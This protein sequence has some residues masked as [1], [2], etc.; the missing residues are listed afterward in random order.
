MAAAAGVGLAV[1]MAAAGAKAAAAPCPGQ[2]E[3]RRGERYQ[4]PTEQL[5]GM[6]QHQQQ[7]GWRSYPSPPMAVVEAPV[8][9]LATVVAAA[10]VDSEVEPA[11]L[12]CAALPE[13]DRARA[14]RWS[15]AA[16]CKS[17][18]LHDDTCWQGFDETR[19]QQSALW[20]VDPCHCVALRRN[21]TQCTSRHCALA[22]KSHRAAACKS[23]REV[24][25]R[26]VRRQ[27][28]RR[29]AQSPRRR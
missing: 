20:S 4:L 21:L 22:R 12:P 19:W 17:H 25:V 15:G 23:H 5:P 7:P 24:Q 6:Q 16:A 2:V 11:A 1:T 18:R 10:A 14:W 3:E 26:T 28:L 13:H 29:R 9:A 8:A 27:T